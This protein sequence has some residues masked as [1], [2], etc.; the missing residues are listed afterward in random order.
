MVVEAMACGTAVVATDC[1]YG[2][3]EIITRGKNGILIPVGDYKSMAEAIEDLLTDN[4]KRSWLAEAGLKRA[5]D[6]DSPAITKKYEDLFEGII[7][8]E[9]LNR[10]LRGPNLEV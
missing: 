7:A 9:L 6:F 8:P 5:L 2:P 3:G 1:D 10:R 4:A